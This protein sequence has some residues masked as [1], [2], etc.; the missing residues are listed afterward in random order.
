MSDKIQ[1][2]PKC[3]YSNVYIGVTRIECGYIES[4]ENY[5]KTQAKE[6]QKILKEKFPSAAEVEDLDWGEDEN[7]TQPY[8]FPLPDFGD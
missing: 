4:C 5:T 8:G 3:G 7:I 6:V 1:R 2:C